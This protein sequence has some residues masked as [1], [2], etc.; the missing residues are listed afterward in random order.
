VNRSRTQ[1]RSIAW[2]PVLGFAI[3]AAV[4]SIVRAQSSEPPP[5]APTAAPGSGET[6]PPGAETVPGDAA[7]TAPAPDATSPEVPQDQT[8]QGYS[9]SPEKYQEAVAYARARYRLYFLSFAWGLVVVAGLLAWRVAPR[10]RDWAERAASKRFLQACVFVPLMALTL[11][12]LDLP[13]SIYG[14]HLSR[15]YNQSIQGWGSWTWDWTKEALIEM[16]IMTILLWVVYAVIRRSPRRW[17]F[18][19]WLALLPFLVLIIFLTPLVIDPMFNTFTPLEEKQPALVGEIQKVVARGGLE[20]PRERMYEMDA[21]K[22]R[23]SVNAYVTGL[24]ASKRV[25]VWDT[26]LRR[27]TAP[28][29]LYVFGHEMGHYV[30]KHIL[31]F[32]LWGAAILLV[33]LF[34]GYH[35]VQRMLLRW[36]GRWGIRDAGDWASLPVLLLILSVLGF[37]SSPATSTFSRSMEH[38]ADIYGLEVVHGIVPEPQQAAAEAFQ[39]LGEIN[40]SDPDPPA[41]IRFWLYSHPPLNER[42]LFVRSYDPWSKGEKPRF[43]TEP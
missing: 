42:V 21:S 20:I 3:L 34:V 12:L 32:L 40:L 4:P 17:W 19:S 37:L 1:I 43:V 23:N 28:Q 22:K 24:G 35:G 31:K 6:A 26:T 5:P 29:T 39:I 7:E 30:L 14:Q 13:A 16:V 8:A 11:R 2:L 9:L 25:V 10:F 38:E 36:G 27:M 18:Y 33:F 41:F 15:R